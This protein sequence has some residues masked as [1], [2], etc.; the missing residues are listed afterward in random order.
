MATV[1]KEQGKKK[2]RKKRAEIG[3]GT[4][5]KETSLYTMAVIFKN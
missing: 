2:K 3:E 4:D 5:L 1:K